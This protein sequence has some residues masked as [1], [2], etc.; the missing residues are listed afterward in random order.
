MPIPATG[1]GQ[2]ARCL[3]VANLWEGCDYL[4]MVSPTA[5]SN[6][7]SLFGWW[8]TTMPALLAR[9]AQS[10]KAKWQMELYWPGVMAARCLHSHCSH[11]SGETCSCWSERQSFPPFHFPVHRSEAIIRQ[12][13][14]GL[15]V[16]ILTYRFYE[17]N[18]LSFCPLCPGLPSPAVPNG[19]GVRFLLEG[20]GTPKYIPAQNSR[21]TK[22][23]G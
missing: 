8:L 13:L 1:L 10:L 15:E 16:E 23:N 21:H 4:S 22:N 9:Q 11:I 3:I 7:C 17:R 2:L 19:Y 12:L 5:V 18:A 14:F 6:I 20:S